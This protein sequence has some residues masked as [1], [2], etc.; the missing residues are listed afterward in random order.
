MA[1]AVVGL[2]ASATLADEHSGTDDNQTV[3]HKIGVAPSP[4]NIEKDIQALVNFGTRH[5]L[6]ETES[7]TRG[8][9]AARRWIKAEF[10]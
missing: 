10:G 8:I 9:G 1:A 5:T 6:S 4:T 7:N 2:F 3:L